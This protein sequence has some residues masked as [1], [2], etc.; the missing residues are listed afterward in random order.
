MIKCLQPGH[1]MKNSLGPVTN[2]S[3]SIKKH[4]S[5]CSKREECHY[6]VVESGVTMYDKQL[7]SKLH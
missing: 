4:T 5:G 7:T 2:L 1:K 6:I 3:P